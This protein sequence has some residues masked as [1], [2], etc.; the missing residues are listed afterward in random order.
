MKCDGHAKLTDAALNI[1]MTRC[2]LDLPVNKHACKLP[3]FSPDTPRTWTNKNTSNLYDN[4]SSTS[5]TITNQLTPTIP[6]L[7]NFRGYLTERVVAIDLDIK[8]L[9]NHFRDSGQRFHFMK[10]PNETVTQSYKNG[11]EFIRVNA[12]KWIEYTIKVKKYRRYVVHTRLREDAIEH[13]ALALHCLQDTFSPG[14]VK[15]TQSKNADRPGTITD[16]FVFDELNKKTHSKHDRGSGSVTSVTGQM[17][18][19]ASVDLM[20]KCIKAFANNDNRMNDWEAFRS[21]W[22]NFSSANS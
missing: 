2:Q 17:A 18:I 8:Y 6:A 16:I 21:K 13:L 11:S 20:L 4:I 9:L 19:N 1:L 15:R 3:D 22:I 12:E 14:H 7:D 5:E 10:S